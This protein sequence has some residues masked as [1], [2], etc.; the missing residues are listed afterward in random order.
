MTPDLLRRTLMIGLLTLPLTGQQAG[1]EPVFPALPDAQIEL[2]AD[3]LDEPWA[4]AFLPGGGF[5]VTE[6]DGL[7]WHFDADGARNRV[8]G[9]PRIAATGQGGLLDVLVPRDFESSREILLSFVT[10]QGLGSGTA[11]GVGRLSD[12]GMRLTGFR[13]LFEMAPGARGGRHY[14]SR[15][16]E[17]PDGTLFLT[18]GDRGDPPSAQDLSVE[19]GSV[20][21]I[22]RDGSLPDDNPFRDQMSARPG[23]WSMG[24]RNPQGLTIDA[25]GRVWAVEHGAQGGDEVNLVEPGVNYGWPVISY[26][27]HYNGDPIGEGFAKPGMAQPAFYWDPSIAPSGMAIYAG[28]MFPEWEGDFLI[29]SLKFD[30]IARLRRID[31]QLREVEGLRADQT[32]RVRDVR[33]APDGSIWFLSVIEGALFRIYR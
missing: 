3:D 12:D 2:V 24:H 20:I 23:I 17:H 4:V 6:R 30:Y 32:G 26:G 13:T 33:V 1:A 28:K 7:L 11:L 21:R 10:R 31:G 25:D 29:G 14:G 15:I 18:I 5:L 27:V 22:N 16:A 8:R 9:L 19:N